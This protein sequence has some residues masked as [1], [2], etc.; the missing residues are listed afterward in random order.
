[1]TATIGTATKKYS[2]SSRAVDITVAKLRP[3]DRP[4]SMQNERGHGASADD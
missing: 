2:S 3:H 4:V 1:M